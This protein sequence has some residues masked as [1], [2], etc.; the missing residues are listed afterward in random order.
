MNCLFKLSREDIAKEI[1][2]QNTRY[3]DVD[4]INADLKKHKT[5]LHEAKRMT[6]DDRVKYTSDFQGGVTV[7]TISD[8]TKDFKKHWVFGK[9]MIDEISVGDVLEI[10]HK[11]YEIKE[12]EVHRRKLTVATRGMDAGL[13]IERYVNKFDREKNAYSFEFRW[14]E[15]DFDDMLEEVAHLK[16]SRF[17]GK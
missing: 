12:I 8:I 7:M 5:I 6:S 17:K 11:R 10:K 3:R 9:I 13:Q 14:D 16:Y 15:S 1:G 2:T 4:S